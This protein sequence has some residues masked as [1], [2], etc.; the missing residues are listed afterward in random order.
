MDLKAGD[1]TKGVVTQMNG[2]AMGKVP[3]AIIALQSVGL[4]GATVTG[5]LAAR[6]RDEIKALN[7]QLRSIN[8]EL[9]SRENALLEKDAVISYVERRADANGAGDDDMDP[10]EKKVYALIDEGNSDI[11]KGKESEGIEKL[12]L[13][14]LTADKLQNKRFSVNARRALAAGYQKI[15]EHDEALKSLLTAFHLAA[16]YPEAVH[17]RVALTGE[18]ADLYTDMGELKK[19]A[20]YY[21]MWLAGM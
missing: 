10:E 3:A 5:Y 9:R 17:S 15:G 6:R 4:I 20:E 12:S 16:G 1:N 21:D 11:G 2:M 7:D 19:A 14:L 8:A 18:I 13:A